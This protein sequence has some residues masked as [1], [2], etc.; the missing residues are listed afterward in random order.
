MIGQG[1]AA[2]GIWRFGVR[3]P[4]VTGVC[5]P[6][7]VFLALLR[8][9]IALRLGEDDESLDGPTG[10]YSTVVVDTFLACAPRFGR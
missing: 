10:S 2:P 1:R 4:A 9:V 5:V 6:L 8:A 7:A 3:R